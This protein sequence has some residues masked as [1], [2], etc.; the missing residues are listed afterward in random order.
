M[1]LFNRMIIL[2]AVAGFILFCSGTAN[3]LLAQIVEHEWPSTAL[4]SQYY[5]VVAT[6]GGQ[7]YNAFAHLSVPNTNVDPLYPN[8]GHGVTAFMLDRSLTYAT[9]DFTGEV[10]LQVTKLY[11][12]PAS[13][14]EISPKALGIN[15]SYFD[16]NTVRFTLRH[17][18]SIPLYI[19]VNFICPENVDDDRYGGNNIKHGLMIFA[20]KPQSD[21]PSETA[22]GVV[23]YSNTANLANASV[24]Y[25]KPGEYDLRQR[26]NSVAGQIGQMPLKSGQSVYIAGGAIV[27]GAFRGDGND[28]L[29]IY[30]RGIITGQKYAWHWFRDASGVKAAYINLMG[31]DNCILQG[32]IIENPTHH[33]IPSGTN[34]Q[35]SDLK[36]IGWASNHDGIRPSS[37]SIVERIFIKTSD[38]YDY[39]RDPHTV[40]N[41]IFWPMVNGAVGQMG[42]NDLGTGYAKYKNNYII[43]SEWSSTA[44]NKGNT[45]VLC[46]SKADGGIKLSGNE[47]H[48]IYIENITNYLI[49]SALEPKAG[50]PYGYLSNFVFR[51]IFVEREFM[52]PNGTPTKQVMRG[53]N[54]TWISDWSFTN[55]IV[56]GTVVTW[57][58]YRDYF[59]LN[60]SGSNGFNSDD[61]RYVRNIGFYTDGNIHTI[62]VT[63]N[64]GGRFFPSGTGGL[65]R[66]TEGSRQVIS[67]IPDN[68]KK[69]A[70]IT[71]DGQ[72]MGRL[73]TVLFDN[74]S[75][76]HTIGIT[77]A[78]GD[79]YFGTIVSDRSVTNENDW[80]SLYPNPAVD[81][82]MI[83]SA[84]SRITH[85]ELLSASGKK[86]RSIK[87]SLAGGPV[88][89]SLQGLAA[90]I[91]VLNIRAESRKASIPLV[92]R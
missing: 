17:H 36:I 19:S 53:V 62:S 40:Q 16:G 10:T 6:N 85:I 66:A 52:L 73:Q 27:H 15:P 82:V 88:N 34:T 86:L 60:L 49:N 28:N 25:F 76:S 46:G 59:D 29:K 69:I 79:D 81:Y 77:F 92:V 33:T 63:S 30:G 54:N 47:L 58:N 91:Y 23:V 45:G 71:I 3:T 11:G 48:D 84:E 68:G 31:S 13:R 65:I 50:N 1:N 43:N 24:I 21:I 38:D 51:N 26:F 75:A 67:I 39:A 9:I 56:N 7:Q 83:M 70:N 5:E 18:S 22:P 74:I 80:L 20:N 57:D 42:W 32:I 64:E 61:A 44:A 35:I 4:K 37:G 55:L 89:L 14:V 41:S 8:E 12:V 72:P 90:G 2:P 78:D 87:P